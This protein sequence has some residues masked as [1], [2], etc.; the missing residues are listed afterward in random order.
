M[1][2]RRSWTPEPQ[3][4]LEAPING[5]VGT[6]AVAQRVAQATGL[7]L[8]A[9][10]LGGITIGC[11]PRIEERDPA[12]PEGFKTILL[13]DV[14]LKGYLYVGRAEPM[15]A[16]ADTL[17]ADFTPGRGFPRE[18]EVNRL[19]VWVSE[20]PQVYGMV[21]ELTEGRLARLLAEELETSDTGYRH[22]LQDNRLYL[23]KGKGDWIEA[24]RA[25]IFEGR[26]VAMEDAY[27]DAWVL[28]NLL[29]EA[30]PGDPLAAGFGVLDNEFVDRL[31][32]GVA[33]EIRTFQGFVKSAKLKNLVFGLYSTG[34][35]T[36]LD[37]VG[38]DSL[39]ESSNQGAVL[40]TRSSYPGF[41][42]S[43]I[44]GS[45]A[46]RG[47]FQKV[48]FTSLRGKE[49]AFYISPDDELHALIKN[50]GNLFTIALSAEREKAEELISRAIGR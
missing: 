50:R 11:G 14:E 13:P 34:S 31:A 16:S 15:I 39:F 40:A 33:W 48:T 3:P 4:A 9:L 6:G 20:I 1:K 47:G 12:L 45:A 42:V 24:L 26:F 8:L 32:K 17:I 23:F 19:E 27:P 29:P 18:V 25:S 43:F 36:H 2:R 7:G 37:G 28:F 44:F 10:L 46:S 30:P 5:T 22:R 38:R 49:K 35:P 21:Y 41:L